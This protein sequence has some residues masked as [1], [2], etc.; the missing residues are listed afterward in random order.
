MIEAKS[1]T[2]IYGNGHQATDDISFFIK[3]GEIVGF[4]GPNGAG[5]T[6]VI[7]M[8]TG[9]LKPT[10]GTAI[11]NGFDITK[12]PIKAKKSFAY[13]ADN[14]DILIQLTGLEYLN[15][16]ADMYEV[17]EE[18]RKEKIHT[19]AERFGMTDVLNTQ[20]REYSHGMR[21]KLMVISALIHNP[22]A[23]ILDEPMTGLDPAAAFELKQMM[24]EHAQAGNAVLFS[25]HVLEVA[26]QLC[27]RILI[28]KDGKIIEEGTLDYLK[29]NNP[30]MTLEEIF[31]KLTG[32]SETR[33]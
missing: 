11:I 20:M 2:M 29:L 33:R 22:P 32:K 25:T 31:V 28:V 27:N 18:Y 3:P 14:P 1:L 16:I 23:W 5:K 17:S 15:F 24:R 10:S 12:D 8:L 7:K 4:A 30:G 9:I 6:T 19:L 26:E 13:I 21:Q